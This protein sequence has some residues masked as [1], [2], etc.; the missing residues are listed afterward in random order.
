LEEDRRGK[1]GGEIRR[2]NL[3]LREWKKTG[4]ERR[5][6]RR[7]ERRGEGGRGREGG[8]AYSSSW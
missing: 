5:E 4:G 6:G 3:Q 8:D 7:E 1:E 2:K